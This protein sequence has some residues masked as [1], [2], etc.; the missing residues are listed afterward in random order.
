M[1]VGT[2]Y[3]S[4]HRRCAIASFIRTNFK[5]RVPNVRVVDA[6]GNMLGI[7]QTRD[8][9]R[10]A[11][12]QDLDLVE[13]SPNAEPPVCKIM[14]YGKFRYEESIK[15]KQARK[16]Q[17]RTQVKEI[18]F[19]ASVDV[20]DLNLKI[21]K[22][23]EFIA[24]GNK[25]KVTLQF[26]GRENAHKELGMEVIQRV[27]AACAEKAIVEQ[28]P[29]LNGRVLGCQ[30][31]GRPVAKIAKPAKSASRPPAAPTASS[32]AR[33]TAPIVARPTAPV[34][35]VAPRLPV[36]SPVAPAIPPVL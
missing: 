10:L 27:I 7:M 12:S 3:P 17:T 29:R 6:Q 26:R 15:Q 33:P 9:Q 21:R 2:A 5:I 11:T 32:A 30:L 25:V 20:N 31:G 35:P 1:F 23:L 16:N 34:A 13:T 22:I 24:E 18:K 36:V 8:A 14:D 28:P 19:H 4:L